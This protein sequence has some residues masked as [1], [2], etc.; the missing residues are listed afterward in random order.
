M[1]DTLPGSAPMPVLCIH[2][3][4]PILFLLKKLIYCDTVIYYYYHITFNMNFF[5][6]D[7]SVK[8]EDTEV[9]PL[10]LFSL[11]TFFPVALMFST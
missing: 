2:V 5:T 9:D 6:G 7:V 8:A 3:P 1:S 4:F 10:T 11:K